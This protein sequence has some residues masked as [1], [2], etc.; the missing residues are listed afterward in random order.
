M[1]SADWWRRRCA[2]IQ[3]HGMLAG[4]KHFPGHG[5]TGTDTHIALAVS[6]SQLGPPGFGGAG[7]V[8]ERD[9]RRGSLGH[10]GPYRVAGHRCRS[11]PPGNGGAQYSHRTPPRLVGLQGPGGDR[12][13]QHG[14]YCQRVRGRG[15]GPSVSRR[16]RSSPP[17][18]R[19][20]HRNQ[21][22]GGGAW[23]GDRSQEPVS[24]VRCDAY[25]RSSG[26]WD[27]SSGG[28]CRWTAFLRSWAGL[29]SKPRP[30]RWRLARS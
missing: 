17:A 21:C 23:R 22:H 1:R 5:D 2:G 13:A 14:G 8:S 25:W 16:G 20:G 29:N 4:V 6:N 18:G 26:S 28:R 7:A 27:C 24:T 10:V 19:S 30:G 15:R 12:R 9:R 11:A 3:D